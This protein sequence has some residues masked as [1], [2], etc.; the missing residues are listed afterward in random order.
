MHKEIPYKL[1]IEVKHR[2]GLLGVYLD[3]FV[4]WMQ[5]HGYSHQTM[6]FYIKR[7]T[8]FG[9]YLKRRGILDIHKLEATEGE[10]LLATYERYLETKGRQAKN[11]CIRLYIHAMEEI[12][13]LRRSAPKSS[14]LFNETQ[15]YITYLKN[16]KGLS[17]NTINLYVYYVE[18]F[19]HFIGYEKD[20]FPRPIFGIADVDRF[21]EQESIRL[22]H[23]PQRSLFIA[24]RSFLGFLYQ[25]G[26]L[27]TDLSSL[28][29]SPRSYSLKSLP[30]ALNW[31]EV[32]KILDKVD[33][34]TKKGIR[35]YAILILLVTYGLRVGEVSHLLLEN[36]DW[37]KETIHITA[38]KTGG[39]LWLPLIPH[40]GKAII[41]YL[42]RGRSASKCREI[43]LRARAPWVPLTT[44]GTKIAVN[45][46]IR[47]A[48][49]SPPHSGCHLLRHSFATNLIRRGVCLKEIG[50]LLGHRNLKTTHL[51]TKTAVENLREVALEIPEVAQWKT[52]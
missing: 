11:C 34:S 51:Y 30:R 16:S 50:D 38:R 42:K 32:Q 35:D 12:G 7:V 23:A 28:V 44:Q 3:C 22:K 33:L 21:I 26:K 9:K 4:R 25:S 18:K 10:K 43:F 24:L 1:S 8:R 2:A 27:T 20:I 15:Q 48:G 14:S 41:S 19:L 47:L 52:K 40:V 29:T 36:I 5:E 45:R 13:I 6:R 37:R 49:F 31:E 46:Y 17:K 39:D